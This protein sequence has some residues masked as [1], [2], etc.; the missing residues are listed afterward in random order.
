MYHS[1][2]E[3]VRSGAAQEYG[4]AT[5]S[6]GPGSLRPCGAEPTMDSHWPGVDKGTQC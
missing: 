1:Q 3:V 2:G 5:G 6:K 4:G